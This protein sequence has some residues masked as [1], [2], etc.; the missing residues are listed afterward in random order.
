M[1]NMTETVRTEIWKCQN[2]EAVD[3]RYMVIPDSEGGVCEPA[4][5]CNE[6][7]HIDW[8]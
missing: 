4:V 1:E 3:Y 8:L 7:D 2:C 5:I 6:C